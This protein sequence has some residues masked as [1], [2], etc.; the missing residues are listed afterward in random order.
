M[1]PISCTMGDDMTDIRHH[2]GI[3]APAGDVYDALA[4]VDGLSRW[5]TRDVRGD[6]AGGGRLAFHF[7]SDDASAVMEVVEQAPDA[8]VVWR[9]VDGPDEWVD[10][11]LRF[12]LQPGPE[13]TGVRFTHADWREPVD[14]LHHCS[15]KWAYFLLSL[16]A[17]LEHGAGTPHPDDAPISS[18]G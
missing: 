16:K 17:E 8:T 9:C 3:A 6:A 11:T 5:W 2:V 14:F 13:E 10:T 1:Q 15:T 7:G 12:E 4:T 18:W